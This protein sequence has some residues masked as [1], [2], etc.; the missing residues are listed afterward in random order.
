MRNACTSTLYNKFSY[1][2]RAISTSDKFMALFPELC[3]AYDKQNLQG[4]STDK[5]VQVSYFGAGVGGTIIGFG[6]NAVAITDDLFRG[7]EDATSETIREKVLSWYQGT[8]MSRL[9]KGCPVIDIGSRWSKKDIIGHNLERGYYDRVIEIPAMIEGETFCDAVKSTSEYIQIRDRMPREIWEAEF[10]QR[11]I[12]ATGTLFTQDNLKRFSLKL[13][14]ERLSIKE[15]QK[16][17]EIVPDSI[18]G[19][20]DVADEGDDYLC[21][22]IGKIIK[23]QVY[24][25]DVVFTRD[26]IDVTL[27]QCVHLIKSINCNYVRV[28]GNN[29]G[30]GMIRMLRQHLPSNQILKVT[31]T[32]NKHTRILMQYGN[33][34]HNF[35]FIQQDEIVKNSMYDRYLQNLLEYTKVN[36]PKHDDAPDATAGLSKFVSAFLPHLFTSVEPV[37]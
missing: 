13:L 9:E 4:W 19:Y 8:H 28:E 34:I 7:F 3:L 29:Q 12:E 25:T 23:D 11:P 14:N 18:M 5:A 6:A 32:A 24:V 1:D 2:T 22:L 36:P 33:I 26:G 27:P 31:N 20:I 30:T 10:M 37:E 35:Q 15:G 16:E 21:M 17:P